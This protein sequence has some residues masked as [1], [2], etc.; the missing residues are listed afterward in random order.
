MW[1]TRAWGWNRDCEPN[2]RRFRITGQVDMLFSLIRCVE[3]EFGPVLEWVLCKK[4][5]DVQMD[6]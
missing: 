5:G 4:V 3:G 2:R 6:A 1:L